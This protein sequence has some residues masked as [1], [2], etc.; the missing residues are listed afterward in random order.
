MIIE[1]LPNIQNTKALLLVHAAF[2]FRQEICLRENI[3]AVFRTVNRRKDIQQSS[4]I[5]L[6]FILF[7]QSAAHFVDGQRI[8]HRG[9]NQKVDQCEK[10]F[11][12]EQSK[13]QCPNQIHQMGQRQ[14]VGDPLCPAGEIIQR[15]EG[16]A[17]KKHRRDK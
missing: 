11:A 3:S 1:L 10:G 6:K 15:K 17:E 16:A 4:N 9:K 7:Y 12:V 13:T 5:F 14:P 8:H 2:V